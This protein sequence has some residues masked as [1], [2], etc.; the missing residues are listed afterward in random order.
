MQVVPYDRAEALRIVEAALS[1]SSKVSSV[2]PVE[3]GFVGKRRPRGIVSTTAAMDV[4]V[5]V[6][7]VPLVDG[8]TVLAVRVRSVDTGVGRSTVQAGLDE[9][10][11]ERF[12]ERLADA[13]AGWDDPT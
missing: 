1:A 13:V 7:D 11:R 4:V 2:E 5:D 8:G 9:R 12:L 6:C 10:V 3:T